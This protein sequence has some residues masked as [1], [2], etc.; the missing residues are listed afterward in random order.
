MKLR[1]KGDSLRIRLSRTEINSLVQSGR[2]MDATHFPDGSVLEFGIESTD[3]AA[4]LAI[5][6]SDSR[7][8]VLIPEQTATEWAEGD[9]VGV[10]SMLLLA[11]GQRTLHVL[12]EKDFQC[13]HKRPGEDERDMFPNPA[14]PT[15]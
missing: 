5:R 7:L 2:V 14:A 11:D 1:L 3:T 15:A 4:T 12:V 6:R 9:E 10:E 8:C 13:L